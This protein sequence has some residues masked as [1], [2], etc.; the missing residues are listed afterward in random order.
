MAAE[1]EVRQAAQRYY[2]A[3]TRGLNGDPGPMEELWSHGSD[4]SIMPPSGSR[5]LGWEEVR[6]AWEQAAKAFSGGQVALDDV[7]VVPITEDAAY[8]LGTEHGHRKVAD[9]TV[10]FE[11][12]VTNVYRREADGWKLRAA[13]RVGAA[14]W[15]PSKTG[16]LSA[17]RRIRT[18]R[19]E[20]ASR[21]SPCRG[22]GDGGNRADGSSLF[23]AAGPRARP[24]RTSAAAARLA[25]GTG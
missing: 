13:R 18:P 12:R 24:S 4:V 5:V 6:A 22:C 19:P 23:R 3:Q 7:V 9:Q 20:R 17:G 21:R 16:Q 8:A 25:R 11:G 14:E 15:W 1:D 2:A 10:R